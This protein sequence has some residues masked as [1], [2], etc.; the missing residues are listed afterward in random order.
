MSDLIQSVSSED[1]NRFTIGL[2]SA[3]Q[4]IRSHNLNDL[5][6]MTPDLLAV[7]FRTEN[8]FELDNFL[9]QKYGSIQAVVEK[10]QCGI[11]QVCERLQDTE[12]SLGDK[13]L[14][15]EVIGLSA[16]GIAEA[17]QSPSGS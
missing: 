15:M 12:A 5:E 17:T 1:F 14:L 2:S 10:T 16:Q 11:T 4:L 6:L 9:Q 8:R 13:I 7:L 3:E